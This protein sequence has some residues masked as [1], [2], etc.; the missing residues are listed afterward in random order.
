[1]YTV[2]QNFGLGCWVIIVLLLYIVEVG[3]QFIRI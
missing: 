1:M 2:G 3:E